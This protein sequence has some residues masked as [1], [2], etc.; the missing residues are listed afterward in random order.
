MNK[1]QRLETF[2]AE[3]NLIGDGKVKEFVELCLE[4]I[5]S[6]FF[7][8]PASSTGKYHP[9][10]SLGEGG[11]VRHTQ[12]AVRIANDLFNLDMF[13]PLLLD[14]PYVIAA[15]IL[16]DCIKH[17]N[18]KQKYTIHEHPI[19]AA[20]LIDRMAQTES[21]QTIAKKI[22][23]LVKSHMGQWNSGRGSSVKLPIPE[24]KLENFVHLC[25]YL[26]SRK[27]YDYFYGA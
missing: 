8:V 21:H 1:E 11:L 6:Y 2:R 25:D 14:K 12:C 9:L 17:G 16:H 4:H 13:K 15:L 7:D 18:P 20:R 22:I 3:L 27:T 26:A 24:N 23:P 10:F 19:E 5:P